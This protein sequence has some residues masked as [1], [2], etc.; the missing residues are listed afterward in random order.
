MASGLDGRA[1]GGGWST[2]RERGSSEAARLGDDE[3]D[4]EGGG[5][6]KF[7]AGAGALSPSRAGFMTIRGVAA[8]G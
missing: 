8:G 4:G 6:F 2:E 3:V 1:E 5:R 7:S